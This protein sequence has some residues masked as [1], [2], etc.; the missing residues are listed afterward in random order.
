MGQHS[1]N[2]LVVGN[3]STLHLALV[4]QR[5]D[6]YIDLNAALAADVRSQGENKKCRAN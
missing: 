6:N 2:I 5:C 3:N 4:A 1:A